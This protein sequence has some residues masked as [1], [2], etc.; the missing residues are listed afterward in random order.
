MGTTLENPKVVD[1]VKIGQA[2]S[3]VHLNEKVAI[4]ENERLLR[5]R[6]V[7]QSRSVRTE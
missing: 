5:N 4:R 6:I 2:V 3:P 7:K 1:C